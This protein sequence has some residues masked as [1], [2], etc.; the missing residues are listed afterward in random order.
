[1]GAAH[2]V[3]G[4]ARRIGTGARDLDPAHRRDGFGFFL[5]GLAIVVAAREWWGLDGRFGDGVHAVVAGTFGRVGLAVPLVL[6]G[7]GARLL[8]HPDRVQANNRVAVGLLAMAVAATGLVHVT[9][10]IPTPPGGKTKMREAGGMIG[11]LASSPLESAVTPFAAI[12][13]LALLA[14]F[15]LL[16]ITATPVHAIP[17]RLRYLHDRLTGHVHPDGPDVDGGYVVHGSK[18]WIRALACC[19]RPP[20]RLK[21]RNCGPRFAIARVR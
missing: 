13:L 14:A 15:G 16:V 18:T 21:L 10:G 1:M 6:L 17:E 4:T 19:S 7:L 3:G 20:M 8:R 12:P 5:I 9:A 2:V 11:Y